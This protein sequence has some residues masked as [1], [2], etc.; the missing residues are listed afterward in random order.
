MLLFIP[1]IAEGKC[2]TTLRFKAYRTTVCALL[3]ITVHFVASQYLYYCILQ[4]Q[5]CRAYPTLAPNRLFME[6]DPVC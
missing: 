4:S 2:T 6:L 1:F 5:L 3:L